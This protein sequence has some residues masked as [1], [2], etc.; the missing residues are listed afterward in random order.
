MGIDHYLEDLNRLKGKPKATIADYVESN[1]ILVPQRFETLKKAKASGLPIIAR[2]ELSQDYDG[3]SDLLTSPK[4]SWQQYAN[5]YSEE[6]LVENIIKD[7]ENRIN[8]YSKCT[9]ITKAEL[10]TQTSFSLWEMLDG[11]T[12][13]I[14]GDSAIKD[15]YHIMTSDSDQKLYNYAIM[16]NK[17]ILAQFDQKL[18]QELQQI[19]P[20]V[21]ETY[22]Q[23]CTLKNFDQN[24]RP[25]IELVYHDSQIKFLQYHRCRNFEP[26]NFVLD[27]PIDKGEVQAEFV[28]GITQ[29]QGQIFKVTIY[30]SSTGRGNLD[31]QDED[32]AIDSHHCSVFTELR[33]RTRKI[34]ILYNGAEKTLEDAITN[35]YPRSRLFK[36]DVSIAHKCNEI[37]DYHCNDNDRDNARKSGKN[38]CL[39][40]YAISD[41]H[42]A[43][44]KIV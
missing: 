34:Q 1:G 36:P 21:I 33:V 43:F 6:E 20:R 44:L 10:I 31:P 4:L 8:Q 29:E 22:E 37:P 2:G 19:L 40:F 32:G 12:I 25:I 42:Q 9:G 17:K 35:H 41:G 18:T 24:H 28:R 14:V 5:I 7:S 16:E 23:T 38:Y 39:N 27:R 15:R 11:P 3:I 30:Y 13:V 26:A